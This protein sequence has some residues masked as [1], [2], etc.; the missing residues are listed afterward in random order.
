VTAAVAR[1]IQAGAL[2]TVQDLGRPGLGGLLGVGPSGACDRPALRLANRLL[3]NLESAAA[4]ELTFGGLVVRFSEAGWVTL[5]GAP[6]PLHVNQTEHA[7]HSLVFVPARGS[8]RI[9]TPP[10]GLRSYLAVRGGFDEPAVLGSRSTDLLTGIGPAVVTAGRELRIGSAIA[11]PLPAVDL[12]PVPGLT[13]QPVLDILPGPRL[14]WFG[15]D[16][17]A[18]LAGSAYQVSP[19]S[20]RIALRLQGPAPDRIVATE[21]PSEGL[22]AGAIQCP[23]SGEL[24]LFL[25]DHPVTGGY[26]VAAVVTSRSLPQAA[27][28]RPGDR[29]RFR[30]L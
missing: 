2:T 28:A 17:L 24:V 27:Q 6:C 8:L 30:L 1:V 19:Q 11:G 25:A 9:G 21:L 3:G 14:D 23:P 4:L 15:P 13:D 7:S 29:V 12:A 20:N 22:V 10:R 26:P 16:T 18:L 5:T